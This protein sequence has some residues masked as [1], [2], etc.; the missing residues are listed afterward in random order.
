MGEDDELFVAAVQ[1]LE[2]IFLHIWQLRR[3][4]LL[5]QCR[6]AFAF[7]Q[8]RHR[9]PDLG[10]ELVVGG[11]DRHSLP[12][13]VGQLAEDVLLQAPDHHRRRQDQVQLVS[14]AGAGD[15]QYLRSAAETTLL[16][17]A[18]P[19]AEDVWSRHAWNLQAAQLGVQLIGRVARRRPRQKHHAFGGLQNLDH[20]LRPLSLPLLDV[21][22]LVAYHDAVGLS[23]GARR[24]LTAGSAVG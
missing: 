3:R 20:S 21:V 18:V 12:T 14:V 9:A 23:T 11:L 7:C 24:K 8:V 19:L 13:F 6:Q 15:P 10:D 4:Q 16:L 5:E 22:R 1:H 2:N 17:E